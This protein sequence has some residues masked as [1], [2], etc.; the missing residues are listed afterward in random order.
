L[1]MMAC[2]GAVV[3]GKVTGIEEYI[4]DG[5][6]AIVVEQGDIK[7]ARDAIKRLIEDDKL[8]LQL[9]ENGKETAKQ[10]RWES[11]IDL[12]E[13]LFYTYSSESAN[14]GNIVDKTF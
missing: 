2:G 9:S 10:W 14:E 5:Y 6:N 12:L 8:R 7:G 1:E 3:V 4:V 13:S 11:T